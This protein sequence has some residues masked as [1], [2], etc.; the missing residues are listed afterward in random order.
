MA[1]EC[2]VAIDDIALVFVVAWFLL[3]FHFEAIWNYLARMAS[4]DL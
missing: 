4:I 2:I 1:I 3:G